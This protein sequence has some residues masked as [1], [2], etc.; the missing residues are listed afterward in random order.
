[1]RLHKSAILLGAGLA[2]CTVGPDYR[3]PQL[4]LPGDFT[5]PQLRAATQARA[6]QLQNW[7]RSFNDPTLDRLVTAMLAQN[8]QIRIAA[9]RLTEAAAERRIALSADLPQID[10]GAT[11]SLDNSSTTL[12]YP[13]GIGGYRAYELGFDASWELDIFGGNRRAVQ[14]ADRTLEA[15]ADDRRAT[16]V[17]LLGELARAYAA[18][19]ASQARQAIAER[20]IGVARQSLGVTQLGYTRGIS[21]N[22]AVAQASA[23]L[24]TEQAALPLLQDQQAKLIDAIAVLLGDFPVD[25]RASLGAPAPPLRLPPSIPASLPSEVI[26]NRPDIARAE[27]ILAAD[28]ARIGVAVANLY[29]H[30]SIPLLLMPQTS[31]LRYVFTASSLAWSIG[32][33]ATETIYH[34]GRERAK[35]DEARAVAQADLLAYRQTVLTAFREV[36]DALIDLQTASARLALL[37]KAAADSRLAESRAA[38]L[39]AAGLADYL[40]VLTT[41]RAVV[42]AEDAEQQAQLAQTQ[43][44]ITLYQSLG[45]GWQGVTFAK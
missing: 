16:L 12:Q 8:L 17:A 23:E 22:L 37:H 34:G 9:Q 40:Q 3:K 5:E 31:Y 26:A 20:N 4:A 13:P 32:F 25:L 21:S 36:E 7:W 2:A 18:L 28:T 1:V 10:A 43:A 38:R 30:F 19:R 29:P 14:A 45:G 41:Q 39:F 35:V 15:A 42:A 6:G 24:E 44:I 27:R 11:A 33:S